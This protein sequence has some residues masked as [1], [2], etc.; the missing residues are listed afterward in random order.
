MYLKNCLLLYAQEKA[1]L[2]GTEL[3]VTN[4]F[5]P[6]RPLRFGANVFP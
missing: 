2:G 3:N 1:T 5:K 4:P 6:L